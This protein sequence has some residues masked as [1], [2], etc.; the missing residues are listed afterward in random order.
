MDPGTTKMFLQE[1][2]GTSFLQCVCKHRQ[3]GGIELAAG[4]QTHII[5]TLVVIKIRS[6]FGR[7][8]FGS[9]CRFEFA[10]MVAYR[11]NLRPV[12]DHVDQA[13]MVKAEPVD[14]NGVGKPV[15]RLL[16]GF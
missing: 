9:L 1:G 14:S 15:S 12:G 7:S 2:I 5:F 8:C 10:V 11:A 4:Q 16:S 13:I 3:A 6:D